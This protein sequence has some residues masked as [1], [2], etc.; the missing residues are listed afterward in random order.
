MDYTYPGTRWLLLMLTEEFSAQVIIYYSL[1]KVI[2]S[3]T[4]RA[5]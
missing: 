2:N 3:Y 1:V 5:P 4:V